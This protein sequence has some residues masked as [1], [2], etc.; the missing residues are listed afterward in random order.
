MLKVYS[1]PLLLLN[2]GLVRGNFCCKDGVNRNPVFNQ[3]LVIEVRITFYKQCVNK[4]NLGMLYLWQ[5]SLNHQIKTLAKGEQGGAFKV[6]PSPRAPADFDGSRLGRHQSQETNR[7]HYVAPC[8]GWTS[9][10]QEIGS[11]LHQLLGLPLWMNIH[12][13]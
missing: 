5:Y 9:S 2:L 7:K 8:W 12:M 4:F 10:H 1:L 13:L 3:T 11:F 6:S